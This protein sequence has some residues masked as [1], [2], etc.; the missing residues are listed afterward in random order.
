ME[1]TSRYPIQQVSSI[2]N[3]QQAKNRGRKQPSNP[4]FKQKKPRADTDASVGCPCTV[5]QSGKFLFSVIWQLEKW[6]ERNSSYCSYSPSNML[7]KY[8]CV[9]KKTEALRID[10][11]KDIQ[12]YLMI[13]RMSVSGCLLCKIKELDVLCGM[14]LK[15]WDMD[16]LFEIFEML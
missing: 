8:L 6:H 9:H 5:V 3:Y 16:F 1:P 2:S 15:K 13:K 11:D 4:D 12:S 14:I 10:F 7:K